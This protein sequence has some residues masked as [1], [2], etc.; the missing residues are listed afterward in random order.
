MLKS[1]TG[2]RS[3]AQAPEAGVELA[4]ATAQ[5]SQTAELRQVS[6][7]AACSTH[8][9]KHRA[10]LDDTEEALLPPLPGRDFVNPTDGELEEL[11]AEGAKFMDAVIKVFCVHTEPNYSLPWQRKRQ[12]ASTSSGFLVSGPEG[13][14]W[15]LTNAHSVEYSSQVKVK[16]RGDDQK[17]LAEVLAVGTEC[18]IALLTVADPAF[19]EGVTPLVF[20]A[21]P[22][23]Q[24]GVAVVGYPIGGDTISVTSGVVSRIEVT[25]YVHGSTELLGVQIDAAINSGNSGGPVFNDRGQCCGIAFQSL[26]GSDAE[27]IGYVIPTPVIQ[28]FLTDFKRNGRYSGFPVLGVKWQ[29]MESAALRASHR[30][31]AG[32]KGVLVRSVAPTSPAA[33][34]L[35]AGDIIMRF[36]GIQ[37]ACDGTV[38][39]RTGER[40]SFHYLISQKYTGDQVRLDVLRVGQTVELSVRLASPD[41]LVPLHLGGLGPSFLITAGIVFTVCC[42]PYLQSEYGADYVSESPVKLLDRLLHGQRQVAD[43][44]VVVLSQVLACDATLG[45]EELYNVQ[46]LRFNGEPVLNLRHLAQLCLACTAPFMRFDLDYDEVVVLHTEAARA[47]TSEILELH[48]IPAPVSRDLADLLPPAAAQAAVAAHAATA[49]APPPPPALEAELVPLSRLH[50]WELG[51]RKS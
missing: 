20:G 10:T 18:D 2:E 1:R 44:Q 35:R 8:G 38:P 22:R 50:A 34:T 32:Q 16:R 33:G 31:A 6:G 12:Y 28:H 29:R 47:A 45:Y 15:L 25:S 49:A 43:E 27:N 30:L 21:L 4:R 14:R 3:T 46:V 9:N 7:A 42:E 19:W 48:S 36:D 11:A 39:F 51:G 40:I 23:L 13:E 26:A 41:A 5:V 24:D 17:F 37:V